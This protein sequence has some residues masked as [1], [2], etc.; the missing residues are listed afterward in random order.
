[1]NL[2]KLVTGKPSE[3]TYIVSE[4]GSDAV[5]IDPG[6]DIQAINDALVE[7]NM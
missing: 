3:N 4:N 5:I 7:N 6:D 1:M 2:I